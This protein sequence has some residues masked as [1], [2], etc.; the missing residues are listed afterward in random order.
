M[1]R[2]ARRRSRHVES[3]EEAKGPVLVLLV[4]D[5]LTTREVERSILLSAG[6][7]VEVA[8]NGRE[9]LEKLREREP[10]VIVTDI[11]MPVMDGFELT[12]AVRNDPRYKHIPVIVVTSRSSEEDR[13]KGMQV[14]AQAYVVKS[15]F[16]QE[17][18]LDTIE[19]LTG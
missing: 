3:E 9:A 4:E 7:E 8:S 12:A 11:E 13:M 19:R 10:D 17:E 15:E 18:L 6:Y 14:G 2:P 1:T 16:N 5:S